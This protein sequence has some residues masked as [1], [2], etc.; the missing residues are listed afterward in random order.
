[1]TDTLAPTDDRADWLDWRRQG[2]GASDVAGI[3]GLSPWV[4]PWSLWADKLG[5]TPDQPDNEDLEF[6]RWA[7]LM[8]GPWFEHRTGLHVASQQ[9]RCVHPELPWA[10]CTL[11]GRVYDSPASTLA[12]GGLEVK[13]DRK[14]RTWDGIPAHYQCQAQWQMF[15]TGMD[16]VWLPVLHGRRLEVYE[17]DRD[18]GDID[19]IVAE[20]A[21]FWHD[22]V[23]AGVAPDVDGS[24]ATLRALAAVYPDHTPGAGVDLG[25]QG[26]ALVLALDDARAARRAAE[27][28]ENVAKARIAAALGDA[29]EGTVD[30]HRVVTYRTQTSRRIDAERLRVAHPDLAAEF[31]KTTTSRVMRP[32]LPKEK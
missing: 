5:L 6:G 8:I 19:L 26:V 15:V 3:L 28:A 27:K 16:R 4:S 13:T 21:R 29:E 31:E 10:R 32:A 17:L 1:V 2:L 25:D 7:E 30:G 22:H 11:D 9:E 24:D 23:V 20:A 14:G 12:L 18:Q